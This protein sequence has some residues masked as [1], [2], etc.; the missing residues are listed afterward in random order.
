[1][2]KSF[3][4]KTIKD[5]KLYI[6]LILILCAI[7]SKLLVFIPMFIQY[8]LD[9]VIMGNESVIPITIRNL[10]YSDSK[11]SKI[12]VLIIVLI[13]VNILVFITNYIKSKI[14]TKFILIFNKN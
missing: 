1:M 5:T 7:Y 13:L 9:G 10:F 4:Y 3:F 6:L 11:I 8:A 12:I 2:K 14:N